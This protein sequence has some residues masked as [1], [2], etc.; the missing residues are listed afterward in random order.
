MI[1]IEPYK[2]TSNLNCEIARLHSC[3]EVNSSLLLI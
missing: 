2:K 1:A 3:E